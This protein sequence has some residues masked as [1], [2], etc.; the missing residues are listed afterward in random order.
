MS[1][2]QECVAHQQQEARGHSHGC[3]TPLPM[4][5]K[6]RGKEGR[7]TNISVSPTWAHTSFFFSFSLLCC[8]GH[9]ACFGHDIQRE[10][11]ENWQ[12]FKKLHNVIAVAS[13]NAN[14][15]SVVEW[16]VTRFLNVIKG[17]LTFS[18]SALSFFAGCLNAL[19][20]N[21]G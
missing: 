5:E 17:T 21:E 15:I 14:A 8:F 20:Q 3:T 18:S 13:A 9:A 2:T 6:K 11:T 12:W 16:S 4:V 7:K 19:E 1:A 10:R